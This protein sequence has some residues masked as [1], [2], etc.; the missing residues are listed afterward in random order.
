MMRRKGKHM[1]TEIGAETPMRSKSILGLN[2]QQV[3]ESTQALPLVLSVFQCS[4][5][6]GMW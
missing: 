6:G 2:A 4:T 5:A 1:E 3:L